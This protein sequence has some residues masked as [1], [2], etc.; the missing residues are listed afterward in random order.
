[1]EEELG[2]KKTQP[3][4]R[5]TIEYRADVGNNLIEHE[6]VDL[7]LINVNAKMALSPDPEEV[8]DTRWIEYHELLAEVSTKPETFTPWLRIYLKDHSK[9][10]FKAEIEEF[11]IS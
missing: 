7:F 6:V 5:D 3:V 8:M 1:M 4:Y 2:L 11:L 9:R 10:I